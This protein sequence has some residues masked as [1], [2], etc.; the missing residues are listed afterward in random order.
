[1][2]IYQIYYD[3]ES[4]R[5]LDPGFIP[6]DNAA[7]NEK[8]W[9]EYSVIRNILMSNSFE[10]HEY[11]GVF[12]P[13]FFE[14]TG[15]TS[16][17]VYDVAMKSKYDVISFSPDLYQN[18]SHLN[19]IAQA[20]VHHPGFTEVAI[21]TFKEIGLLI[22]FDNLCQDQTTT[23]FSNYFIAKYKFWKQWFI[24]S[25]KIY[26]I[27]NNTNSDLSVSMNL[28]A[29][30]RN[31]RDSY[32]FKIFII[33]RLVGIMLVKNGDVAQ[34]GLNYSEYLKKNKN[35]KFYFE[36]LLVLDS[37]KSQYLK[38]RKKHFLKLYYLYQSSL[39]HVRRFPKIN[40]LVIK[41]VRVIKKY[42]Y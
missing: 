22:D 32:Q 2:K 4:R 19:S 24:Y 30:H 18:A 1:M 11:I 35:E 15:M 8:D 21:K 39:S 23:I 29:D 13:R 37:L 25:E 16:K 31:R 3:N 10:E 9:Y 5:L 14:K 34:I 17:N 41:I 12:S 26:S 40:S 33:E 36:S 38:T 7:S 27:C 20:N 6:F 28:Y 42:F